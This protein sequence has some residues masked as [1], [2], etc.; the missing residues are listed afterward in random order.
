M[1]F[2][3]KVCIIF[4]LTFFVIINAEDHHLNSN[5]PFGKPHSMNDE[6]SPHACNRGAGISSF[7][8]SIPTVINVDLNV[9]TTVYAS[10]DQINVTWPSTFVAC[11][12]D[13]IGVYFIEIPI[14]TGIHG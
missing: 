2:F 4:L 1:F 14:P 7:T 5:G 6:P 10:L 11:S 9:S 8:N 12:D 3:R 13:F